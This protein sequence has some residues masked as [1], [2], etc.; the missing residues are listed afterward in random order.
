MVEA[1]ALRNAGNSLCARPQEGPERRGN[2][3]RAA[4]SCGGL[5]TLFKQPEEQ[6]CTNPYD[7]RLHTTLSNPINPHR[8]AIPIL[9]ECLLCDGNLKLEPPI[10]R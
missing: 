2:E 5:T 3:Q 7:R 8:V 1:S 9:T 10:A 6:F 4:A